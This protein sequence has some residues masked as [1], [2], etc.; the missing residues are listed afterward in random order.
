MVFFSGES[1]G[2]SDTPNAF[3]E[4]E[5]KHSV[6]FSPDCKKIESKLAEE[7]ISGLPNVR[8]YLEEKCDSRLGSDQTARYK[9]GDCVVIYD[10]LRGNNLHYILKVSSQN[11]RKAWALFN[12]LVREGRFLPPEPTRDESSQRFR[13]VE[14]GHTIPGERDSYS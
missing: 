13:T 10:T 12:R 7:I 1:M 5:F 4:Q 9:V 2:K 8:T 11:K 6:Y 3:F 14:N